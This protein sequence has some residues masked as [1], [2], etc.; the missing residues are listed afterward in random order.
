MCPVHGPGGVKGR[1]PG[2]FR[3]SQFSGDLDVPPTRSLAEVI[4]M[5]PDG[6]ARSSRF[7]MGVYSERL[8]TA[9]SLE[10]RA[11]RELMTECIT[12]PKVTFLESIRATPTARSSLTR[13]CGSA[14]SMP[15]I[16]PTMSGRPV[17]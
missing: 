16:R 17:T 14:S 1:L 9:A 4:D 7:V 12:R 11:Y 6:M 5:S 10:D 2:R 3:Y 13:W 15:M 8:Q